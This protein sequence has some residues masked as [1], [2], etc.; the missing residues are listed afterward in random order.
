MQSLNKIAYISVFTAAS[1]SI[2]V[3]ES[4]FPTPIPGIR[5]GLA[6]IF[7]LLALIFFGLKEA[8][9]IG[10]LKSIVGSLILARLL[11]PSFIFSISG[12]VLST[13]IM[14]LVIHTRLPFSL[15]G[16]SMI[17]AEANVIIQLIIA[18]SIFLPGVSFFR[19]APIYVLSSIITG[20]ITGTSTYLIYLKIN[21]R[22]KLCVD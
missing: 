4:L 14:W 7:I 2:F 19:I 22:Y 21:R 11:T 20:S 10:I 16:I 8:L 3:I 12:T 13:F 9:L 18:V 15:L 1:I 17:G 5:L 6:N